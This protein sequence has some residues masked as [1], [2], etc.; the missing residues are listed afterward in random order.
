M[1]AGLASPALAGQASGTMSVSAVVIDNCSVS[2]SPMAFQLG[3]APGSSATAQ[4]SVA[5]ECNSP[6]A[7]EVALDA[8]RNPDGAHR[9]MAD[10][11]T[12]A[13]LTY[14]IYSDP[15]HSSRWGDRYG[16]DTVAGTL[17]TDGRAILVAYGA[18]DPAATRL[19]PGT[20]TDTVVVTVAF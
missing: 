12:G 13:L 2:A 20:Y 7:Y 10:P 14:E 6:M 11:G 5:L 3:N 18:I 1:L 4:S 17:E 16:V 19:T 15:S 8:G 9:R